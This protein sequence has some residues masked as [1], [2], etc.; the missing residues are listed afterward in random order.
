M[1]KT[2]R[3][4]FAD[5]KTFLTIVRCRSFTLAAIELGQ[6]PSAVSHAMRRLEDRLGA[7][8][9]NRS[10]RAVSATATG[11]DLAERLENGFNEIGAALETFDAPGA[12]RL[13]EIRLNVFADAAHLL[14]APALPEFV[15]LC[16]DVRLTVV[17]ENRPID[18]VAE[19]YDAGIRYGHYVP[20]DMVAVPL[21][22]AQRWV[23]AASPSYLDTHG[24]P[25]LPD[26]LAEHVCLQLLL[27]DNS[28][29]RWEV[30][31]DGAPRRLRVPGLLTINDTA[32][33]I[34]ACK[35]GLGIAYVL[36]ARIADELAR[37]ELRIV[38]E[39][40]AYP[41]DPFHIYYSSRR[42]KHPALL[43]LID[44]IREQQSLPKLV[45]RGRSRSAKAAAGSAA[46]AV[47][48]R[49]FPVRKASSSR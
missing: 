2:D 8:L 36:E 45:S 10:S 3:I 34:S 29:Y 38:L 26:D 47:T 25:R 7:K 20:E 16:P 19:G 15:R 40:N 41:E 18:I 21:T 30:R 1:A 23:M 11:H 42:Y 49:L 27:G 14:I 6:T 35:A 33:T 46:T 13:G 5:L 37:G 28:S 22:G 48:E 4:D 43:T 24:P 32:T 39:R 12:A 17:V 44:I 9:L 31:A